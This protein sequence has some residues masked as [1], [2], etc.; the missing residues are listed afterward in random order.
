M[1]TPG[2]STK[3]MAARVVCP[4]CLARPGQPCQTTAKLSGRAGSG[5]K[6]AT[7]HTHR[8]VAAWREFREEQKHA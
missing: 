8:R 3:A 5:R 1:T 2:R 7:P 6:L 4:Y